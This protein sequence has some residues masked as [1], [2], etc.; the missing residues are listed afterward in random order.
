MNEFDIIEKYFV[1]LTRGEAG[2]AGLRDDAAVLNIPDGHELV[3]TSDT[4]NEGVH[5]MLGEAPEYIAKKALRVNL[6]DLAAMGA[7]PLCYQLNIAFPEKPSEGWL[8][9]FTKALQEDNLEFNVFCSGGDTTGIKGHHISISIT[10]MGT[11]PKGKAITRAGAKDGDV[12]I[13]TGPIGDAVLG[14]KTLQEKGDVARYSTSISHYLCPQPRL[15]AVPVLREYAHAAA[16]ISD[17]LLADALNIGS[18]SSSGIEID[19]EKLQFSEN[20]QHAL[21]AKKISLEEILTGG[22]DYELIMAV[23]PNRVEE[24][25]RELERI[26]LKPHL[27]GFFKTDISKIEL[28]NTRT[29]RINDLSLGW[30]HF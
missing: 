12:I 30:K 21:D 24:M 27:I 18:A 2:A 6:S 16:D 25:I 5:F 23:S 3:V 15:D 1:P 19:V 4:L 26:T 14:L 29:I 10:A 28:L 13:L 20:V 7:V 11:V 8:A 22:D 9:A 17:G